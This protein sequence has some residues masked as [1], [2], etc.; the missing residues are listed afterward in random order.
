M[1][2]I[3]KYMY[4]FIYLSIISFFMVGCHIDNFM[5]E[6]DDIRR[7]YEITCY[8]SIS[9]DKYQKYTD[10]ENEILMDLIYGKYQNRVGLLRSSYLIAKENGLQDDSECEY[11]ITTIVLAVSDEYIVSIVQDETVYLSFEEGYENLKK[12]IMRW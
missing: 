3:I 10:F 1:N 2:K 6:I 9:D 7:R 11:T 8:M 12:H 4:L 5:E